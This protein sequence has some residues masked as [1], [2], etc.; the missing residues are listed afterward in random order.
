MISLF[1]IY[2]CLFW[3]GTTS[4]Q[5]LVPKVKRQFVTGGVEATE[6]ESESRNSVTEDI[7]KFMLKGRQEDKEE[8]QRERKEDMQFIMKAI[9]DSSNKVISFIKRRNHDLFSEVASFLQTVSDSESC[10]DGFGTIHAIAWNSSVVMVGAKHVCSRESTGPNI[11]PIDGMDV[12]V[13]YGCPTTSVAI[14]LTEIV[15]LSIGG[16]AST[17]GFTSEYGSILPRFWTGTLSGFP[18]QN[19]TSGSVEYLPNEGMYSSH[20]QQPGMSGGPTVNGKGYY[21]IS[22]AVTFRN[23]GPHW[24]SFASV[25]P[26]KEFVGKVNWTR[27]S[28]ISACPGIS[29]QNIPEF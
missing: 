4:G 8:R 9:S 22:H 1:F 29:I 7:I 21:G 2:A 20:G 15:P 17:F 16:T 28:H 5:D 14:N 10:G 26:A 6:S 27:A 25:I 13:I 23:D 11:S 19:G 24:P 12:K 18:G 3:I